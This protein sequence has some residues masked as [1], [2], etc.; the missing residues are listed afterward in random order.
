LTARIDN[1]AIRRT[2]FILYEIVNDLGLQ[3][4][5]WFNQLATLAMI[6]LV[7]W[8]RMFVHYVGQKFILKAMDAPV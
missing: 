8:F 2:T 6:V 5:P 4:A 3:K 7:F 1:T